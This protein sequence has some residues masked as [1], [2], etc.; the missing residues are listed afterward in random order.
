MRL[1]VDCIEQA[2]DKNL[3]IR[4]HRDC[5]DRK[6][7]VRVEGGVER[8]VRVQPRDAV[9]RDRR[10]AV[11]RERREIAAKKNLAV[12]L[13]NHNV[14][15]AIR[16]RIETVER[17]LPANRRAATSAGNGN[18]DERFPNVGVATRSA[19]VSGWD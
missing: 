18:Q 8:A 1:S 10:S 9:A 12:R 16:V 17:G 6:I 4:L 2:A 19:N 11:G 5:K 3:A 7:R 15:H 13:D 14:N